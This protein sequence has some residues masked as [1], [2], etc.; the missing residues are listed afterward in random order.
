[1]LFRSASCL[2]IS[3]VTLSA[4]LA[5]EPQQTTAVYDDW[6]VQCSLLAAS[7]PAPTAEPEAKQKAPES[8]NKAE[9]AAAASR[10]CEIVQTFVMRETGGALAKLAIGKLPGQAD[11]KGVLIAPLGVY[12]ADGTELKVDG[13][14][15]V[16]GIY[17]RCTNIGCFA[18]FALS[19]ELTADVRAAKA[20]TLRFS[21]AQGA[22]LTLNV[23]ARGFGPALDSALAQ[24]R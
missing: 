1:M 3:S 11:I 24:T 8:G 2:L 12:L 6:V 9:T 14:K 5:Q 7:P 15:E 23:S 18:E 19:P 17:T 13:T 20:V 22:P 10:S 4:T 21:T 16:K